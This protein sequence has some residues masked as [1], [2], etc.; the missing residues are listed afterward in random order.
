MTTAVYAI[1]PRPDGEPIAVRMKSGPQPP[2]Q[3]A[4]WAGDIAAALAS[5]HAAGLAH[6]RVTPAVI[7]ID[8]RN[9]ALL[10]G[11][12]PTSWPV[13]PDTQDP[14]RLPEGEQDGAAGDQFQLATTVACLLTGRL[15]ASPAGKTQ[16]DELPGVA[17]RVAAVV[18]RG[19]ARD[20]EKRF[21]TVVAFAEALAVAVQQT[22]ED[23]VAGVWEALSRNDRAMASLMIDLAERCIPS[24]A[25]L[26]LLR[27]RL[28][29]D[30]H[31]ADL[32]SLAGGDSG[33]SVALP[34]GARRFELTITTN[35]VDRA[36]LD[37]SVLANLLMPRTSHQPRAARA[38]PWLPLMTGLFG[39]VILLAL[40]MAVAFAY[41]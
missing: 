38:N 20:S 11:L 41:T 39:G 14:W 12:V 17:E 40:L 15:P 6:G 10:G 3:V 2:I 36:H 28:N 5:V 34:V 24:H 7:W 22:G 13:S 19:M 31:P 32:S 26:P 18:K 25:D 33:A 4:Q 16:G 35:T 27:M 8:Q 21:P 29:G 37:S 23:L 30:L 1:E 9:R